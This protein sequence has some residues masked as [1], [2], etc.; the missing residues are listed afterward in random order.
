MAETTM[1]CM[2][3]SVWWLIDRLEV[4]F[5]GMRGRLGNKARIDTS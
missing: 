1:E 5:I 2:G 4:G 3:E